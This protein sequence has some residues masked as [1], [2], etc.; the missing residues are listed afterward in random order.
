M[1][2]RW[3]SHTI[4]GLKKSSCEAVQRAAVTASALT[5]DDTVVPLLLHTILLQL[6]Q[7]FYL[8]NK[9]K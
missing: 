2:G 3:L 8:E 6:P 1:E 7:A 4:A 9:I 5:Q